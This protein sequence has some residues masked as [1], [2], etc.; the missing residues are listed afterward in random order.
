MKRSNRFSG[1]HVIAILTLA[2]FSLS[3]SIAVVITSDTTIAPG[4]ATYEG[5]DVVVS[6]ATLTVDGPHTFASLLVG[7]NGIVTHTFST[8]GTIITNISVLDEPQILVGTNEVML[9]NQNITAA[10]VSV[11]DNSGTITYQVSTDF[12]V[13]TGGSDTFLGRSETST[14]PDGAMVLVSYAIP[15]GTISSGLFLTVTG[16]LQV[17]SGGKINT[18]GRGYGGN[19]GTGNGGETGSPQ[20]GAGAG[21]GGYGGLSSSNA[22]GG[23]S[24]G[25]FDQPATLG[26]GGGFGVITAGSPGGGLARLIVS[27]ETRIDGSVSANALNATNSRSGGGSGGSIWITTDRFSGSGSITA[28]GGNGEPIHGGGGG[29]GRIAVYCDTN[30]F[31]GTFGAYGGLGWRNGGAGT[32]LRMITFTN[33]WLLVDNNGRAGTN[34][35][36]NVGNSSDVTIRSNAIVTSV[37]P[38]NVRHMT[39]AS[40]SALATVGPTTTLTINAQTLTIEP[41]ASVLA[42]GAGSNPLQGTSP[43]GI[44]SG[45]G[46]GGAGGNSLTNTGVGGLPFGTQ[47]QTPNTYGSGGGGTNTSLISGG[48]AGGGVI[49]LN[50]SNQLNIGGRVSANGRDASS[51][52]GGGAG[53]SIWI[54][55]PTL[56]GAGPISANG[57]SGFVNSGGGGGGRIAVY[58]TTTNQFTGAITA[59]GGGGGNRGGAGTVYLDVISV[60]GAPVTRDFILDN[61]GFPAPNARSNTTVNSFSP[62][63]P[64]LIVRNGAAGF[65]SSTMTFP[66]ITILSNSTLTLAGIL[67]VTSNVLIQTGGSLHTDGMGFNSSANGFGTQVSQGIYY[68]GGGGNAGYGGNGGTNNARG[69]T[70]GSTGGSTTTA[71]NTAGG[72]GGGSGSSFAPFGGVGGGVLGLTVNG[73]LTNNG[74]ISSDGKIGSGNYAG[75]GAGGSVRLTLANYYGIGTV[76]ANGGPGTLPGGGGGGGGRIGI[77][78]NSN[79]FTGA[80]TAYGGS[81]ANY[82]GAGTVYLKTNSVS[83]GMLT[84]DN[85]GFVATNTVYDFIFNDHLIVSGGGTPLL[86]SSGT[87]LASLLIKSNSFLQT[88][89]ATFQY[90]LTISGNLT[91]DT[92]GA[93]ALDGRGYGGGSGNSGGAGNM[94]T[95]PRGGGGH[96]GYGAMNPNQNFGN[97]YGSIT[98]PSLAGSGGGNGSGTFGSPFGGSGGGALRLQLTRNALTVNGRL[99]VN[100]LPGELNSGGGSGGSLLILTETLAGSD[101]ISANGGAG[102]GAAGGGGGGRIFISYTSNLFTGQLTTS[103]G[104]GGAAGGA[105]TIYTKAANASFGSLLIDNASLPGTNTPLSSSFSLPTSPFNLTIGGGASVFALTQLPQLSNLVINASS[106]L[107]MSSST[108][109]VFLDV[110]RNATIAAGG[111]INVNGKGFGR[112]LGN[113]PGASVTVKGAGG[114]HGGAGGNSQSGGLGGTNYDS[115]TQPVLRGSGGGAGANAYISGCEGGGA[116]R[117]TV[118]GTLLLSGD[119]SA[120][121]APGIQD[122]SGG[123]AGGS[124]WISAG[125]LTGGGNILAKGGDGDLFGGGGGGGGRIAIYSPSNTFSGLMSVVGGIGY[126]NGQEGSVFTTTNLRACLKKK[127]IRNRWVSVENKLIKRLI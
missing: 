68:S 20:S 121:G 33:G 83:T 125:V 101:I 65:V 93:F 92:G 37:N 50:I 120:S 9:A 116:I 64:N 66:N 48:G 61:G 97:A 71:P 63:I 25:A 76:S 126:Q 7:S 127:M 2:L 107:T 13:R 15:G 62:S 3:Q 18:D 56:T 87:T 54:T 34:T 32:I 11:K 22:L 110:L 111:A 19:I 95:F 123:G 59:F 82:G 40:N 79:F 60:T 102:N 49:R 30:N 38:W 4:N 78:L 41:T 114:G 24:Y 28:H 113:S 115:I 104:S 45:G 21:H 106:V 70:V 1:T 99:S 86:Q 42:D 118:G 55:S 91:I 26:S 53:G 81:G 94:S 122:D 96:G 10:T 29:G 44:Y 17:T 16:N 90:T 74:R 46:H 112:G 47:Q 85:G 35:P 8:S 89:A 57:G 75:G 88:P 69:G 117:M 14:I 67:T 124:V 77:T 23:G 5:A 119:L 103:G 72:A 84:V 39:I 31:T 36:A 6:N 43:G 58:V 73:S 80:I 51:A 27:G 105:G 52:G 12:I 100:G 108:T 109:N 98:Q